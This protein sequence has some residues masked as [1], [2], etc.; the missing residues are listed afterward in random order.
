MHARQQRAHQGCLMMALMSARRVGS[1]HR[2]DRSRCRHDGL[3]SGGSYSA[4]RMRGKICC[5]RTML[6]A[7]SSPRRQN[8]NA[9]ACK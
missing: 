4:A 8:G 6:L 9:P 2:S 1:L 5:S 3:A 7:R